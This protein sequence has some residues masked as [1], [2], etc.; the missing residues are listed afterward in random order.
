MELRPNYRLLGPRFG[1]RMPQVVRAVEA[2]DAQNA[3]R[4]LRDGGTVAVNIEGK[5]HPLSAEELQL[6][7]KPL[8]GYQVERSGTH[9]VAIDLTLDEE[10]LR[11]GLAR[12]VVHAVQAARKEAGLRVEDRISLTL[13]GDEELLAAAREHEAYVTGETLATSISYDGA[14]PDLRRA[15][16]EG[17]EL[18]IGV[19]RA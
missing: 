10:L 1:K 15:Q 19:E 12:E 11:E 8:E 14:A 16:I 18:L 2:L 4:T 13:G 6:A 5:D 7:L 17:R 3:A 9:A